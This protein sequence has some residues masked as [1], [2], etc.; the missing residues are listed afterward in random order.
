MTDFA[1][2]RVRPVLMSFGEWG[3]VF[4]IAV[5]GQRHDGFVF[6]RA[7]SPRLLKCLPT[8]V[9]HACHS[10]GAL[11]VSDYVAWCQAS[12]SNLC[13]EWT[14]PLGGLE[15]GAWAEI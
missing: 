1:S 2:G 6:A 14:P 15:L 4:A 7:A 11:V 12:S 13:I 9:G 8:D 5:I 3:E 10:F